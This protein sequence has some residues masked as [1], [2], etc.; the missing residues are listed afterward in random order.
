MYLPV[1]RAVQILLRVHMYG[2]C[3]RH[4]HSDAV[5]AKLWYRILHRTPDSRLGGQISGSP[6]EYLKRIRFYFNADP[7]R[8]SLFIGYQPI[9][10][11]YPG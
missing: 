8:I 1:R 6:A 7:F 11:W 9:R 4:D 3:L 2:C 10:N 5:G